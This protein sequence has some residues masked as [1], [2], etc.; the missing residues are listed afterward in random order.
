MDHTG[1]SEG[2]V[3]VYKLGTI[4]SGLQSIKETLDKTLSE[5]NK[6]IDSLETEVSNLKANHAKDRNFLLGVAAAA[7]VVFSILLR[8]IPWP[9]LS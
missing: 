6:K 2:Q 9:S 5:Q 3:I 1:F 4:E 7:S 8:I